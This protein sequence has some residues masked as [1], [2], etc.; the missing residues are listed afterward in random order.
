MKSV[1]GS[2]DI[3]A[4]PIITYEQPKETVDDVLYASQ[5]TVVYEYDNNVSPS[6]EKSDLDISCKHVVPDTKVGES[7]VHTDGYDIFADL[8][9]QTDEVKDEGKDNFE[10]MSWFVKSDER[11][12]SDSSL[13]DA[14]ESADVNVQD[15]SDD[16]LLSLL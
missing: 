8:L 6:D 11:T 15:D 12:L 2:A 9:D 5:D 10:A 7:S 14:G 4:V 3:K 13:S 1:T 16:L